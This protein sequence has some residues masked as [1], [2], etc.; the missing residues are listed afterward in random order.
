MVS[1]FVAAKTMVESEEMPIYYKNCV[2]PFSHNE[3]N[4]CARCFC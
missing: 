2:K 3:T 1:A 4:E